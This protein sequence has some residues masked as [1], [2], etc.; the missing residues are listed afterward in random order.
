MS[1]SDA[2]LARP[3]SLH[4]SFAT[5]LPHEKL[6]SCAL[7]SRVT[8]AAVHEALLNDV[9]FPSEITGK[10]IRV[11]PGG[12]KTHI[13]YLDGKVDNVEAK[14]ETFAKIYSRITGKT[15]KFEIPVAPKTSKKQH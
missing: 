1:P 13:V 15:T 10:R 3:R 14:A 2:L 8:V 5:T 9:V 6:I 7:P 4:S 11:T 12:A